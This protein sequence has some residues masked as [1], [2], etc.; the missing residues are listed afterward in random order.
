[1][2]A[3]VASVGT[4]HHPFPRMLDWITAAVDELGLDA[5]VQRGSTVDAGQDR[6]DRLTTF[7]YIGADAL[8]QMMREAR[9]VVCHGGPGTI[10]LATRCGHR[11]IVIARDPLRGEHVD[12]HQQRYVR[13]L[14]S[15]GL[16]DAPSRQ[17][18]LIAMVAAAH[19]RGPVGAGSSDPSADAVRR[20][21]GLV[22]DLLAGTLPARPWRG[23][24]LLR[25]TP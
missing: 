14:A 6:H 4:D 20:F 5:A 9:V 3:I 13:R 11:P 10:S 12:D 19:E 7:D 2:T 25:R 22:D 1:M 17:D 8:E 15:E 24:F 16:I 18:E 21:A 23:R